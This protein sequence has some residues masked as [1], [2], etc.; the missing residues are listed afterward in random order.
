MA[1]FLRSGAQLIFGTESHS[2]PSLFTSVPIEILPGV[3]V[4]SQNLVIIGVALIMAL[5]LML[6]MRKQKQVWP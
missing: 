6:F 5:A 1:T 3:S 2:F 4:L